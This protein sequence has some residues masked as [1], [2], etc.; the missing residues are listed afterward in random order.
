MATT[1]WRMYEPCVQS[2]VE[3]AARPEDWRKRAFNCIC[4][5]FVLPHSFAVLVEI[6]NM[7]D[8]THNPLWT[9]TGRVLTGQWLARAVKNVSLN[10]G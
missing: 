1:D 10:L 6:G 2:V 4:G 3:F 9:P 5:A 8:P 7:S